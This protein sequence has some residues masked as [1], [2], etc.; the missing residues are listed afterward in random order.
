MRTAIIVSIIAVGISLSAAPVLAGPGTMDD[1]I[2]VDHQ[3][4]RVGGGAADSLFRDNFGDPYSNRVADDFALVES[5]DIAALRWWGF[6]NLDNP[7]MAESFQ[8]RFLE[9]RSGDGLPDDSNVVYEAIVANPSRVVTGEHVFVGVD[10]A[11]YL[12]EVVLSS[13][14][15]LAANRTYWLEVQ[16][17]GDLETAFRWE[18]SQ[19]DANGQAFMNAATGDWRHSTLSSD[20]AY[21][22]I[23]TPEPTSLCMLAVPLAA[24]VFEKRRR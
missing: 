22:L 2:V 7:P 4:T 21:Q 6:Y 13:P 20:T 15:S 10:P 8:I 16:Q 11:E 3:P 24:I 18:F 19:S 23:A 17:I 1:L 14:V 12:Y 5:T 9:A